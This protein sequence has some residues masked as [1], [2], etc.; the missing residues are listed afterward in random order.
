MQVFFA[1]HGVNSSTYPT[2]IDRSPVPA[3]SFVVI[4]NIL[5]F[6]CYLICFHHVIRHDLRVAREVLRQPDLTRRKEKNAVTITAHFLS[7]LVELVFVI[8]F[9]VLL[10]TSASVAKV[11]AT[12]LLVKGAD[13]SVNIFSLMMCVP[14][15]RLR[16]CRSKSAS[17]ASSAKVTQ[18]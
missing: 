11:H 6:V 17:E 18:L 16:L 3:F 13:F 10:T 15:L 8:V 5:E 1:C 7:W 12:V 9:T 14:A 2:T 4:A